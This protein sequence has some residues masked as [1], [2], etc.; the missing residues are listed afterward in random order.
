MQ[1][2]SNLIVAF[3]LFQDKIDSDFFSNLS[4]TE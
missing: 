3:F 1:I 4:Y 2:I